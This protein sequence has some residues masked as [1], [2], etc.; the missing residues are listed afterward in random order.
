MVCIVAMAFNTRANACAHTRGK[1][2]TK[3][4][5]CAAMTSR[6]QGSFFQTNSRVLTANEMELLSHFTTIRVQDNATKNEFTILKAT[7]LLFFICSLQWS[8]QFLCV[9]Y[10]FHKS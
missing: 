1:A 7:T 9:D 10:V 4:R 5:L 8:C 6:G 3:L 2:P